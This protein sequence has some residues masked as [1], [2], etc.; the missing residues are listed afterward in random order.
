MLETNA[1]LLRNYIAAYVCLKTPTFREAAENIIGYLNGTLMRE[2]GVFGGSQDDDPRYYSLPREERREK[3]PPAVDRTV[4]VNWNS[5]A[6]AAYLR[7]A[8][9][10]DRPELIEMGVRA[11]DFLVDNC[12]LP[13]KGMYHYYD[14]SPHILGLLT[15]QFWMARTLIDAAAYTGENRYLRY[16][17]DLVDTMIRRQMSEH[18]GF[19]DIQHDPGARGGLRLQNKSILQNA[20]IAEILLR[21]SYL[22]REHRYHTL[23]ERTLRAFAEH[24]KQ[25][26]YFTSGYARALDIIFHPPVYILIFGPRHDERTVAMHRVARSY[27]LPAKIV[28]VLD[29]DH[30][31]ETIR[32]MQLGEAGELPVAFVCT[33]RT[34]HGKAHDVAGLEALI[35]VNKNARYEMRS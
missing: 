12:Y 30:D 33:G 31:A 34:C 24:Y 11:I 14:T 17:R 29:P 16:A 32:Q 10:F 6:I 13:G 20:L 15:D 18:G 28:Q 19:Y 3:T 23:A 5:Q 27:Y 2:D 7:A 35:E 25:Y 26:G 21:L 4:Y 8:D 22:T 1:G 9:A